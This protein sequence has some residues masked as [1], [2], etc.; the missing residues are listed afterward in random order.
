[1]SKVFIV[2]LAKCNGCHNCQIVCKDEHCEQSWL[3]YA[4]A[5]PE[6]GQFWIK[7]DQRERGQVPVVKLAY[8]PVIGAQTDIIRDYA[9]EVCMERE[10]GLIVIEPA[11][12]AGR[13]DIADKFEG[14][15]WNEELQIPQGC[16]GCAHLLDDGWEVPRCV[17]AC[18]T[19][20]LRFGDA[21]DFEKEIRESEAT[22]GGHEPGSKVYYLNVPQR[23]IAGTVVDFSIREVVIGARVNLYHEDGMLAGTTR[24]DDFGDFKFDDIKAAKYVVEIEE[25]GFAKLSVDADVTEK[26]LYVGVLSLEKQS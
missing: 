10:D 26:D 1:M 3:P 22:P 19:D 6:G 7:V 15:Y 8:K 23:F 17:D 25:W 2:D 18:P 9:P 20:A 24:T 21:A 13:K 11:K 14:V 4:E 5:E 12:A 16:T